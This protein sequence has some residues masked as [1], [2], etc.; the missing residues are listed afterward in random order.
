MERRASIL[1]CKTTYLAIKAAAFTYHRARVFL[2]FVISKL[3]Q[4][5]KNSFAVSYKDL[6]V[7]AVIFFRRLDLIFYSL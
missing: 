3:N 5:N 1:L 2:V 7:T 4:N 6:T